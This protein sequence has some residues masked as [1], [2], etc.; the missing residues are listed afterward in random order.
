MVLALHATTHRSLNYTISTR[1]TTLAFVN[2]L[3]VVFRLILPALPA[4]LT[5]VNAQLRAS[6]AQ[7]VHLVISFNLP[8]QSAYV[9][10]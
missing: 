7:P 9:H 1:L 4:A 3:Q 8:L 6:S 2:V 5:A 10:V